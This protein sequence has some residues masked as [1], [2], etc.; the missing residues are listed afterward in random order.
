[1]GRPRLTV[2]LMVGA[3][4]LTA[5]KHSHALSLIEVMGQP[6]LAQEGC[7]YGRGKQTIESAKAEAAQRLVEMMNPATIQQL[8][9]T[10]Q[11]LIDSQ[12]TEQEFASFV[13]AVNTRRVAVD[14]QQ[15]YLQGDDTCVV[16]AVALAPPPSSDDIGDIAWEQGSSITIQV[17]G[18]GAADS[19]RQLSARQAA[20]MDA[21]ARAISQVLGVAISSGYLEQSYTHL[22]AQDDSD[23]TSMVDIARRSLSSHSRGYISSW[24]EIAVQSMED[25]RV[26]VVLNVT[27]E[28]E[29]VVTEL[30]QILDQLQHP[31]VFVASEIPS[32]RE[33]V[34]QA[35][36]A[37]DVRTTPQRA[38]S[39]FVVAIEETIRK[40]QG[41]KQLEVRL[42]VIDKT[43]EIYAQWNNDPSLVTLPGSDDSA[44]NLAKI[45]FAN[46]L[47]RHELNQALN[48][49]IK[50][51]LARGGAVHQIKLSE[52]AAGDQVQL[53]NL[54]KAIPG[55]SEVRFEI[56]G[57]ER[58]LYLRYL[59]DA[60]H[61]AQYLKPTLMIHHPDYQPSIQ[62][63]SDSSLDIR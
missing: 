46:E 57:E 26:Q 52:K 15:P 25:G 56:S 10:D 58:H 24:N 32:V 41:G 54:V 3:C 6:A 35:L 42:K 20:E 60:A 8:S 23:S 12:F 9:K 33:A 61:L 49:A 38:G 59:R 28:Q 53:I 63:V 17:T 29:K 1:M 55:V 36:I 2:L 13:D 48:T 16:A 11:A 40:V 30:S 50:N 37:K 5:T 31:K 18:E 27:V 4:A 43:G 45:H 39:T 62:I 44:E 51:V 7:S 14:F 47:N 21:F 19:T 34:I 22:L